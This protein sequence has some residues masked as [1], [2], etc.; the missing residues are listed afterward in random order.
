MQGTHL[1]L[2]AVGMPQLLATWVGALATQH[3]GQH[4]GVK[5]AVMKALLRMPTQEA[6]C[7]WLADSDV[8]KVM[9]SLADT[10]QPD[11]SLRQ[12]AIA[13]KV[14]CQLTLTTSSP[15]RQTY[16]KSCYSPASML[17]VCAYPWTHVQRCWQ[18]W[19]VMLQ[20]LALQCCVWA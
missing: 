1:H 12:H 5:I 7:C 17:T 18:Q 2:A 9:G 8:P 16:G 6:L 11:S 15:Q 3:V 4:E 14:G 19:C 13:C 20:T 10:G